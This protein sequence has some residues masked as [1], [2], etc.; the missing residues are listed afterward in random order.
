[1]TSSQDVDDV[2]VAAVH[3]H[4]D[5]GQKVEDLAGHSLPGLRHVC[6]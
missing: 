4:V 5:A 1:M 3:D 2:H 6:I